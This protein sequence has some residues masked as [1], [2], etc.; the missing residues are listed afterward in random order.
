MMCE[1]FTKALRPIQRELQA[2]ISDTPSKQQALKKIP[3]LVLT[4]DK[5]LAARNEDLCAEDTSETAELEA[6]MAGAEDA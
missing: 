2:S 4:L 1:A 6:I 5:K 3:Q